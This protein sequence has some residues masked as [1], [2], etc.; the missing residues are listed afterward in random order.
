MD[1][2]AISGA[3]GANVFGDNAPWIHPELLHPGA[4]MKEQAVSIDRLHANAANR[5][6]QL[7]LALCCSAMR[8]ATASGWET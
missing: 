5:D 8:S 6:L 4:T 3:P 7:L 1:A 2:R